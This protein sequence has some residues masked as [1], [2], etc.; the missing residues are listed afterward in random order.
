[1]CDDSLRQRNTN[2]KSRER[3][4]EI[5]TREWFDVAPIN[6]DIDYTPTPM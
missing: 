1:M 4:A 5:E 2:P 6:D 3:N